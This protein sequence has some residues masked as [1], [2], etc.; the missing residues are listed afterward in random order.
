MEFISAVQ[1]NPELLNSIHFDIFIV[2]AGYEKRC[3]FLLEGHRIAAD[4]K[5]AI[6]F[7][8]KYNELHRKHNNQILQENGFSFV[9]L[10]GNDSLTLDAYLKEN[11]F[12]TDKNHLKILVDYSC[13]SKLWYST[14]ISFFIRDEIRFKSIMTY[15]SYTP[16]S[17]S[18]PRKVKLPKNA[19]SIHLGM[20]KFDPSKPTALVIGLGY[21]TGRA[22]FVRKKIKPDVTYLM[23]ADP[24]PDNQ[25]VENI[26][27]TNQDII[28]EVEV[29]NLI[30]YPL[31][32]LSRINELL[33]NLCLDLRLK[34]NVVLAPLGPKVHALTCIL[35]STRYPD[36]DVWRIG[37][38][39]SESPYDRTAGSDPLVLEVLFSGDE[40]EF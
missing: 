6:A 10:S 26:F 24:A 32:D 15:F 25:Y 13:M 16:A 2:A 20:K 22:E 31:N 12:N 11:V 19:E 5:F 27:K 38:G 39:R 35:L 18:M 34:Y 14:I 33:T 40:E 1:R 29:R 21:E 9:E 30:N 8:E 28:N 23:Y 3:T 36:V 7:R 4:R 37:T 17:F